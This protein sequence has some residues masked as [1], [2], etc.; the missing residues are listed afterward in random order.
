MHRITRSAGSAPLLAYNKAIL[1]G[2]SM[3]TRLTLFGLIGLF[4]LVGGMP[5]A[6]A[7]TTA[8]SS[9]TT[10][11]AVA[12]ATTW[13]AVEVLVFRDVSAMNAQAETWPATVPVPSLA[14]A[15]Y[16]N[17]IESGAYAALSGHGSLI[18][19]AMLRLQRNSDYAIV[20]TL[21]WQQ[22][23][24][25][26]R[27]VSF[28]PLPVATSSSGGLGTDI[29]MN[30]NRI[31]QPVTRLEGTARLQSAGRRTYLTL[32]LRLCEPSPAG[33]IVQAPLATT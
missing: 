33:I 20:E 2:F 23:G 24:D 16:P 31:S 6:G 29:D 5:T 11:A 12:P 17:E 14:N 4:W 19:N 7:H 21:A 10:A 32:H 1:R 18:A 22:P 3:T 9:T 26:S 27:R 8:T 13:H 30:A 15:V 25:S 28:T